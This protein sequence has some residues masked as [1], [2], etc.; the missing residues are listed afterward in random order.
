MV[1]W[2]P[3]VASVVPKQEAVLS[4]GQATAQ[5]YVDSIIPIGADSATA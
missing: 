4:E 2:E 3:S 1:R 5:L